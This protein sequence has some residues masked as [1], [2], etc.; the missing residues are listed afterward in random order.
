M[1][2][3]IQKELSERNFR[4]FNVTYLLWNI[5][6]RNYW[7]SIHYRIFILNEINRD[8]WQGSVKYMFIRY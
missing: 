7:I 6:K 1:R 8:L 5:N 4:S 2:Q 3:K